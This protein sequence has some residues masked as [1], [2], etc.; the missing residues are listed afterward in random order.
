MQWFRSSSQHKP[1]HPLSERAYNNL[2]FTFAQHKP[3]HPL[4]QD[5]ILQEYTTF[6]W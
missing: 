5:Q 3:Y 6:K 2:L 4:N 1:D